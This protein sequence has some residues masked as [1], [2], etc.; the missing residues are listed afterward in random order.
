MA[1]E[2]RG[3][4]H[5]FWKS[6]EELAQKDEF[7]DFLARQFPRQAAEYEVSGLS[8]R[9]LFELSA[10][11]MALAGLASCTRQPFERV[12]PYVKQPEEVI[13]GKPLFFASAI[14]FGGYARGVLAESHLGRPT[15][16]EGNPQ[17]PASLG[18]T[19]AVT[20]AALLDLYD[21]DRAKTITQRGQIKSW[22]AFLADMRVAAAGQKGRQ[23][24]GLRFLSG[25]ITSPSLA[26]L[27]AT[28]LA[29]NPQARWHQYDAITRD[30]ARV[31][32]RQATG[33]PTN[34]IYHF[35]KADVV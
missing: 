17:H 11:S 29:E 25:P 8:R 15:K 6:L 19:D 34:V 1:S 4:K 27:L 10:A 24:A 13:P 23:G 9:R 2:G 33:T 18:A 21:P 28:I 3:M 14:S 32:A 16:L 30:G 5:D 20:Q 7:P 22:S 31:G 35:D 26:E 12:V